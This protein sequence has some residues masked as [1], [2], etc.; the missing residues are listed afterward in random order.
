MVPSGLLIASG[1]SLYFYSRF[2]Y[3]PPLPVFENFAKLRQHLGST[4]LKERR[5]YVVVGGTVSKVAENDGVKGASD[6]SKGETSTSDISVPFFL[7]DSEGDSITVTSVHPALKINL[8]VEKIKKEAN[9]RK[10]GLPSQQLLPH[11]AGALIT[12]TQLAIGLYGLA[13]IENNQVVLYP[14][15]ADVSV[16]SIVAKRKSRKRKLYAGSC[17]LIL[18]GGALFVIGVVLPVIRVY[19]LLRTLLAL[20]G[21]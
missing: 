13:S 21:A 1:C 16:S 2:N 7:V 4:S 20:I 15:E 6:T 10:S 5:G 11:T 18:S 9:L 8:M 19:K 12:E 14:S 17:F 3:G